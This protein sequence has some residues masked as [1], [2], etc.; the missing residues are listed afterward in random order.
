MTND[1]THA[2]GAA[3]TYCPEDDKLRLYVGRVP[4]DVF[5]ALRAEGWAVCSKQREAGKGDFAAVWTPEREDTALSFAGCID[6][7][8]AGPQER[9]ADRAERFAGYRDQRESDANQL[10]DL[11]DAGPQIHGYQNQAL[12]E[13]RA[14][15]HDLTASRAVN[16]WAKAEYWQRRTAGV[17]SNALYKSA[18]GVRMGRIK[19]LEAELRGCEEAEAKYARSWEDW[20]KVAS[21]PE[22]EAYPRAV[23]LANTSGEWGHYKHPRPECVSDY[24]R[25]HGTWLWSL[26]TNEGGAITGH[27]AA[28]LWFEGRK[29]PGDETRHGA[30]IVR[31]L[32]LRLAYETQMLEAQGGRLA[33]VELEPGGWLGNRQVEQV[34]KSPATGRVTSVKVRVPRVSGWQYQVANV[35]GTDYALLTIET[36]RLPPNAYR[37]PTEAEK[38]AFLAAR[39]AEK[40]AIASATPKSPSLINPTDADAE[41]LQA[42]I[43]AA[44]LARWEAHIITKAQSEY[45]IT[46][47]E[48]ALEHGRTYYTPPKAGTV[49]R[50]TQA[51]YSINSKGTYAR[52]ETR[53]VCAGGRIMPR[54]SNLW[55]AQREAYVKSLGPVLC[56]V[57]VHDASGLHII[58]IT[59]KPQKALPVAVWE[60]VTAEKGAVV[61]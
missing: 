25:E 36:E 18:P 26:L 57:R 13:R 28:A 22:A 41:R 20:S 24:V 9:A 44:E 10:A 5:D 35:P 49:K 33:S 15:R 32:R 53:G 6:D 34:H 43:N 4:R 59:D 56:K 37:A 1:T 17:I 55:S 47:R 39:K 40:K 29:E 50:V 14:A 45:G 19:R 58:I 27:E 60:Q 23:H 52:T 48:K 46:D 3:A 61:A 54:D 2:N 12:A 38:A 11:Y 8:D 7:E 51:V 16:A 42:A 21:M 30:R 31:H